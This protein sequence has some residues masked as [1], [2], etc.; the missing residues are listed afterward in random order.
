ML[1]PIGPDAGYYKKTRTSKS[2]KMTSAENRTYSK[3]EIKKQIT[4]PISVIIQENQK[5]KYCTILYV[6]CFNIIS[7]YVTIL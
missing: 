7:T 5:L 6:H 2:S 1:V 4:E 3:D